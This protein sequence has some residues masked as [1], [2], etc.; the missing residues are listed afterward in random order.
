MFIDNQQ[1]VIFKIKD[2]SKGYFFFSFA[3]FLS[4]FI[5]ISTKR[6]I[7]KHSIP[8]W[9]TLAIFNFPMVILL[10]ALVIKT[11]KKV[12][13]KEILKLNLLRN[14]IYI[15]YIIFLYF[16]LILIF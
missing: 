14:V 6:V 8:V 9:E 15:F 4:A 2:T 1:L 5:M 16:S 7:V 12:I 11:N 10:L 13:T 3:V